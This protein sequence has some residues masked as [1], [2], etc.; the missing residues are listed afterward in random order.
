M[1]TNKVGHHISHQFDLELEDIHNKVLMMGGLVEQQIDQAIGAFLTSNIDI[2]EQ[3]IKQDNQVNAMESAIDQE[4]IAVIALRQPAASDLR[5]LIAVIKILTEIE[6]E[7]DLAKEIAQMAIHLACG[8]SRHADAYYELHHI[9]NMVK[10]MLHQALD[11]FARKNTEMLAE[12]S[13]QD[14]NVVREFK[15]IVRQLITRMM[16]EPRNISRSLDMLWAAKALEKIGVHACNIGE[17]VIYMVK[18]EDVR[19][20]GDAK[21]GFCHSCSHF[22]EMDDHYHCQLK[23]L[24]LTQSDTEKGCSKHSGSFDA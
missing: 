18:G 17:H 9:S 12:M 6:R 14:A 15:G 21:T 8:D 4:C 1:D 11:A 10:A 2:A 20:V 16:E 22:L 5:M 7:G 19:H 23:N 13:V 24:S 3:V